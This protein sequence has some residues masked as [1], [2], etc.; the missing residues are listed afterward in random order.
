MPTS[1]THQSSLSIG[2]EPVV[3]DT[4]A[5]IGCYDKTAALWLDLAESHAPTLGAQAIAILKQSSIHL[6]DPLQ[7]L[8]R[9]VGH[10]NRPVLITEQAFH[11]LNAPGKTYAAMSTAEDNR[12]YTDHMK[13]LDLE[14]E[15]YADFK[16][17]LGP[18]YAEVER[19][20]PADQKG[21]PGALYDAVRARYLIHGDARRKADLKALNS[22]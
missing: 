9:K 16:A 17:T 13:R 3:Q 22:F 2:N 12:I 8:Q 18:A 4:I 7:V 6:K 1:P 20:L 15:L 5:S 21:S 10:M 11:Q 14:T 19:Q